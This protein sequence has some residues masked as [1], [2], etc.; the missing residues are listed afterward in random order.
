MASYDVAALNP[1]AV[2]LRDAGSNPGVVF[3]IARQWGLTLADCAQVLGINYDTFAVVQTRG[4][5]FFTPA[6]IARVWYLLGIFRCVCASMG[7][8]KSRGWLRRRNDAP[9][10]RRA[11]P[12]KTLLS[13][14]VEDLE[15]MYL[16][17]STLPV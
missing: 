12:L 14:R 1:L 6:M 17:V 9:I 3:V 13:G 15:R 8:E 11:S 4:S 5:L 7:H 16:Y 2:S 10:F